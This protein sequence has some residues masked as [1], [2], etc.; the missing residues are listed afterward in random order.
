MERQTT[1]YSKLEGGEFN[2]KLKHILSS[3]FIGSALFLILPSI[4]SAEDIEFNKYNEELNENLEST[5]NNHYLQ[6]DEYVVEENDLN[7][8]VER[9]IN[10]KDTQD[11]QAETDEFGI[12]E[13]ELPTEEDR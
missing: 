8:V 6:S 7:V 12:K 5:H 1:K 10:Y 3:L 9:D 13:K 2:M 4:A 11:S